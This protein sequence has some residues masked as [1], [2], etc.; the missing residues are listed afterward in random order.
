MDEMGPVVAKSYPEQQL[1]RVEPQIEPRRPARRERQ[2]IDY[3]RRDKG[4]VFGAFLPVTG[5]TLTK[6]LSL[7]F[8][9]SGL[10]QPGASVVGDNFC[11]SSGKI[12]NA[13]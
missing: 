3:G 8:H 9:T 11:K 4:Y 7:S 13:L 5:D 10:S 6:T 12:D 1:A 2:E